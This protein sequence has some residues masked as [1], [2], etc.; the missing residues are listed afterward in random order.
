MDYTQKLSYHYKPRKGWINDPNGLVYFRGYYHV[1]YQQ[2]P[3]FEEPW[4]QPMHWGHART[5]NFLTWEELPIALFPDRDYDK[6][7]CWSGTATVKDGV[8]YLLYASVCDGKKTQT[9]S[10]AYSEDGIHFK[11]YESNPVIAHY[12]ADGCPDCR[13][14]AVCR[15]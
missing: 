12:P 5:R 1:F 2:A 9:V 4:H 8:L 7:G 6:D 15:V 10:V 11:K 13:D 14:P 3:D